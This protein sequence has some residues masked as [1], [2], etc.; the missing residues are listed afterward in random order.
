MKTILAILL[1]SCSVA[2]A[3]GYDRRDA[4]KPFADR[5][6]A[7]L[8]GQMQN[9]LAAEA[10]PI[11]YKIENT[12]KVEAPA[13]PAPSGSIYSNGGYD[14]QALAKA[15]AKKP[16]PLKDSPFNDSFLPGVE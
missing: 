12:Y 16:M 3:Q 6:N 8:W 11:K 4:W 15:L 1:L 13:Y 10:P 14:L 2:H 5:H 7:Y 9:K